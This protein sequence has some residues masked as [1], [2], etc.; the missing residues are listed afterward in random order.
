VFCSKI[1]ICYINGGFFF[2][3]DILTLDID[4]INEFF[5][6]VLVESGSGSEY[7]DV[8]VEASS[9]IQVKL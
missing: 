5:F 3:I 4:N 7:C 6:K 2:S 8:T 1:Y 9:T